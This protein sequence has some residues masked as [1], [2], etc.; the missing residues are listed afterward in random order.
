MRDVRYNFFVT[1]KSVNDFM[2]QIRTA[3]CYNEIIGNLWCWWLEKHY[4]TIKQ[5]QL[6]INIL[7]EMDKIKEPKFLLDV[8]NKIEDVKKKIEEQEKITLKETNTKLQET[9]K[10]LEKQGLYNS[11][12]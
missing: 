10:E 3:S 11:K 12:N 7:N 1:H 5:I 2:I 8:Y 6:I 4:F 9:L